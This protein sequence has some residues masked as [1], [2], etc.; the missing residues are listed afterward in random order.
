LKHQLCL[1]KEVILVQRK[2]FSDHAGTE[3]FAKLTF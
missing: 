1:F 2:K 3:G